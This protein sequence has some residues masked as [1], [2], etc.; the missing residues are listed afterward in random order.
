[1]AVPQGTSTTLSM[2]CG[3]FDEASANRPSILLIDKFDGIADR[4]RVAET[5]HESYWTQVINLPHKRQHR[6]CFRPT[7]SPRKSVDVETTKI[8]VLKG[9][10]ICFEITNKVRE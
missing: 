9:D 4:S 1:M 8:L 5:E 10:L 3:S 6:S 2:P 7:S